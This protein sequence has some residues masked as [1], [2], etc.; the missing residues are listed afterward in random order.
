MASL[1]FT[2]YGQAASKAF[3]GDFENREHILPGGAQLA[4]AASW[5]G[6]TDD[7]VPAGTV[8]GRTTAEAEAGAD[9]GPAADT[10]NEFFIVADETDVSTGRDRGTNLVRHGSVIKFTFLPGWAS[11]SA[12]VKA[13]LHESYTLVAG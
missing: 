9:F 5:T 4:V 12:A 3:M 8:V 11:M 1:T 6:L 7:I 10:D 13:A 2:D